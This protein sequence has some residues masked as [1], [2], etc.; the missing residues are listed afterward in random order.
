MK[1][2]FRGS[3]GMR[4]EFR[5]YV[6]SDPFEAFHHWQVRVGLSIR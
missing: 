3:K 6:H 4:I 5:D 2:Q 1:T